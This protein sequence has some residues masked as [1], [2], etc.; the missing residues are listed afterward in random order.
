MTPCISEKFMP[1]IRTHRSGDD[2]MALGPFHSYFQF[3][4][5]GRL[6]ILDSLERFVQV[7]GSAPFPYTLFSS[8][9]ACSSF[10]FPI[11]RTE[12]RQRV[13]VRILGRFV[14][15]FDHLAMPIAFRRP[16]YE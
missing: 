16:D 10:P 13:L 2:S 14:A 7:D 12:K 3:N 9:P 15:Y 11:F 5:E 8:Y 6:E 1:E 4:S